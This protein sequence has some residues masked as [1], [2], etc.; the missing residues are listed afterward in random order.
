MLSLM[1]GWPVK[2]P[3]LTAYGEKIATG[4][5]EARIDSLRGDYQKYLTADGVEDVQWKESL[6]RSGQTN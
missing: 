6:G 1:M 2:N 3:D 4:N 5:V